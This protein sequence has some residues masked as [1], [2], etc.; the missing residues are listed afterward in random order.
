MAVVDDGVDPGKSIARLTGKCR[1][2]SS[3]VQTSPF[4]AR[5]HPAAAALRGAAVLRAIGKRTKPPVPSTRAECISQQPVMDVTSVTSTGSPRRARGLIVGQAPSGKAGD[6]QA[7]ALNGL[8]ERRLARLAGVSVETLWEHFDRRNLLGQFPGR[9]ARTGVHAR[10]NYARHGSTGDCFPLEDARRAAQ[11]FSCDEFVLIVL[12]GLN[13]ARAFD[14]PQP[15]LF[16]QRQVCVNGRTQTWLVLPHP[17]GVSHFW[18]RPENVC[19][20][21]SHMRA[22]MGMAGMF[23]T[24]QQ[25]RVNSEQLGATGE[26]GAK[27][28]S[29]R[30]STE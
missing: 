17:S 15:A 20:A 26:E 2:R 13:V 11:S 16:A 25:L 5:K 8:A 6:E 24:P 19:V 29:D 4:F 22:S 10:G 27:G 7:P 28:P 30:Y 9:K 1:R 23:W 3:I 18:N 21:A 12:L 14:F